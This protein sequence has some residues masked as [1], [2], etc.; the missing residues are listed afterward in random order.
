VPRTRCG[1]S[2]I[3][4]TDLAPR[5]KEPDGPAGCVTFV[6]PPVRQRRHQPQPA[7]VVGGRDSVA[8]CGV[9]A[10]AVIQGWHAGCYRSPLKDQLESFGVVTAGG[11]MRAL[12]ISPLVSRSRGICVWIGN[13]RVGHEPVGMGRLASASMVPRGAAVMQ[14]AS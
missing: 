6:T 7:A 9:P 3:Q 13:Q 12:L 5:Q 8:R 4:E 2:G 11:L 10:G 14:P 1:P